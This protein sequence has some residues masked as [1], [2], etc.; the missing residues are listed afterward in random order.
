M[1]DCPS[2]LHEGDDRIHH[3]IHR[4]QPQQHHLMMGR[5]V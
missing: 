3:N 5:I 2:I 1:D 4:E